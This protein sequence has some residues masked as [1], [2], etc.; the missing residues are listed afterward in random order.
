MWICDEG[1]S[2]SDE[3]APQWAAI[4]GEC[5]GTSAIHYTP[6][7]PGA[8]VLDVHFRYFHSCDALRSN[9]MQC[10]ARS[11]SAALLAIYTTDGSNAT[12]ARE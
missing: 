8:N 11:R 5:T 12:S 4:T 7:A 6:L 3:R 1:I 2:Q 10:N 9:A